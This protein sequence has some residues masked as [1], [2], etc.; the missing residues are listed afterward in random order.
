MPLLSYAGEGHPADKPLLLDTVRSGQL[1]VRRL[2]QE[3]QPLLQLGM[4]WR[5]PDNPPPEGVTADSEVI[6]V[7]YVSDMLQPSLLL[8]YRVMFAY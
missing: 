3:A 4:P 2:S 8:R 6:Q 5:G 1:S 7:P